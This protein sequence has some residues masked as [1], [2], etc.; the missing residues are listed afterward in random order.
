MYVETLLGSSVSLVTPYRLSSMRQ[1]FNH[2][3]V[4][5]IL[6]TSLDHYHS[7]WLI[8]SSMDSRG[9]WSC[10][11]DQALK[12]PNPWDLWPCLF[13]FSKNNFKF[14]RWQWY[15]RYWKIFILVYLCIFL[16]AMRILW[17]PNCQW[18]LKRKIEWWTRA[19][20]LQS[21]AWVPLLVTAP[22]CWGLM[23]DHRCMVC[24]KMILIITVF[25]NTWRT[26]IQN[27]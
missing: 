7:Q 1:V 24:I 13:P 22:S 4:L 15:L 5:I 19:S 12:V 11:S 23:S 21:H 10:S 3:P 27:I 26:Y 17:G 2:S 16:C 25:S 20:R 6:V 8:P 14:F 18:A 9:L